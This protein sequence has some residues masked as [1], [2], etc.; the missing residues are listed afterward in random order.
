[1]TDTKTLI[2]NWI[3]AHG[4]DFVADLSR[5]VAVR[6]VKAEALEGKPY[7]EECARVLQVAEDIAAGYGFDT[8]NWDNYVLTADMGPAERGLDILAHLDVVGEGKGWDTDPYTVVLDADGDTLYGRGVT[9]D[10][11][12]VAAALLAMRCV[13][14]LGLPMSKGLRLIMG[15]DEESGSSDI[16]HYYSIEK[17]APATF[18]PDAW[19]PIYNTE[20][21]GYKPT[22][23]MK[24]A[25]TEALPRVSFFEGGFR[26]NVLPGDAEAVVLGLDEND[27]KLYLAF[28]AD[29]TETVFTCQPMEGGVRIICKGVQAHASLPEMGNNAITALLDALSRLP[30]ADCDSTRAVRGLSWAFP[31]GDFGGE[32]LGVNMEDDISGPMTVVFSI[33]N[34]DETGFSGQYDSRVPIC[35]NDDNCRKVVEAFLGELGF[36]VTGQMRPGHHTPAEGEFVSTLMACYEEVSGL[37]AECLSMGGGTYV[38]NIPG[39]VAFGPGFPGYDSREHGANER[40]Q[41][42]DM[43]KAAQIYALAIARLCK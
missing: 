22:F 16:K 21:G 6:S 3:E 12:P 27:V 24:F 11:G 1:M 41:L 43:L 42:S 2:K 25:P 31:H 13:K 4:E 8:K 20:K 29:D 33:L 34:M 9:D 26:T 14:E 30:L 38:H 7:G 28:A 15:A 5:L 19:F 18:T 39:G 40:A 23:S 10:K 32:A 36:T 35:A 17:P 37:K